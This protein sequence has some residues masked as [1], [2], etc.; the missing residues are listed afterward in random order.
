MLGDTANLKYFERNK[1]T[2]NQTLRPL[3]FGMLINDY[4]KF[5]MENL[6]V[7]LNGEPKCAVITRRNIPDY[8]PFRNDNF[9]TREDALKYSYEI[10]PQTP[11]S[12]LGGESQN[13]PIS[14]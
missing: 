4:R 1:P 5:V 9:E 6:R 2:K 12:S 14:L 11:L 10:V 3:I 13:P 7:T 8:P